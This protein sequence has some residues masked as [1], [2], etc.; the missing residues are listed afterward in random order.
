VK[1]DAPSGSV[2]RVGFD[3]SK[4]FGPR[5]GVSG[6]SASLLEALAELS[7]KSAGRLQLVLHALDAEVEPGAWRRLLGQLPGVVRRGPGRWPR[8][9]D[10]DLFHIPTF[11]DPAC[12]K[13]PVVFTVHDLTFLTHPRFHVP[14]NRNQCLLSTLRAVSLGATMIAVSEATASEIRKWF[15]LP[16]A[17]LRVVHEAASEVFVTLGRDELD[18]ARRRLRDRFGLDGQFV[19]SVGTIEPRKNIGR[20]MKAH[21][22]LDQKLRDRVPLALVGGAGWKRNDVHDGAWPDFVRRL[23][24]V[25]ESDLVALYNAATVVAYPSLVEGFGLPVLEAMAC[26][27]PVLTSD[28]SSLAE[29]AGN[30]AV[31][32]DPHDVRAIRRGLETL[33]GDPSLRHRY[34]E[35]GLERASTFSWGRAAEETAAVYREIVERG[36]PPT[37]PRA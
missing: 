12:F 3:V 9:R 14:E 22:G 19:L 37:V 26:G 33:L 8:R 30:S 24:P 32:V 6:Y 16:D 10:L 25:S 35:A 7:A 18:A 2:L 21:G 27:T 17:S 31:C 4:L 29:V 1:K 15:V 11:A 34:R 5:D 36:V 23:G 20:L 28:R 13:G